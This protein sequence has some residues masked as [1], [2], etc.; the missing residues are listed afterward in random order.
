MAAQARWQQDQQLRS[1]PIPPA[2]AAVTQAA[3]LSP[4]EPA[5]PILGAS[6]AQGGARAPRV[7][8]WD[9]QF[10]AKLLRQVDDVH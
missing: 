7:F 9:S 4:S 6:G 3:L 10:L 2:S 1:S 8:I 5:P